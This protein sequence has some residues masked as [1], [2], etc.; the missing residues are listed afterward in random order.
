MNSQTAENLMRCYRP[1]K[2]TDSRTEKAARFAEQD[3]EL[4]RLLSAQVQ[5]DAQIVDVIHYIKPPENLRQKLSELG[6]KPEVDKTARRKQWVNPAVLTAVL[7]G[8]VILGIVIFFVLD[9]MEKFP[10]REEVEGMLIGASKMNGSELETV[11]DTTGQLGDWFYMRGYDGYEAPTYLVG[12]PVI[13]SRVFKL[14][15]RTV[16]QLAIGNT[17]A[18]KCLVFQFHA[19]EFGVQ[20]PADGDWQILTEDEWVGAIRQRGD[21]CFLIAFRG[22]KADMKEFLKNLPKT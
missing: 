7:G 20:L 22:G 9:R 1:G 10:G 13:G 17:E 11:S 18:L 3:A 4:S 16:A 21:H 8:V 15:G 14:A 5:F 6:D 12:L 2:R 19:S